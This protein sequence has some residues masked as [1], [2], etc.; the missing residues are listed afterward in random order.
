[1]NFD[2]KNFSNSPYVKRVEKPWGYELHWVP[3]D[4][5]YMGKLLHINAEAR[6]SLQYH[7]QKT[8]SWFIVKG[9]GKVIWDNDKGE[10][11]ETELKPGVGY[12]SQIGQRHRLCGITDCDI[13]EVSTPEMGTTWRL[14]D[15]YK[16]PDE[17][18]QQRK[19][20]RGET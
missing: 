3:E 1:M 12:T 16:R 11:V 10:L 7:D 15:D 5:P 6:L 14:E 4:K 18:P 17:T 2:P 20:E 19:K 8:E 13:I 9:Q